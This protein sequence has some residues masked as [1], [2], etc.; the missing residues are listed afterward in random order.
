M[1]S[2]VNIK[3]SR[4]SKFSLLFSDTC[5]SCLSRELWASQICLLTLFAKINSRENFRIYSMSVCSLMKKCWLAPGRV[6]ASSEKN[7][8][9]QCYLTLLC[10]FEGKYETLEF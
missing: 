10:L 6:F 9:C 4:N 7:S 5:K 8:F 1:R 2:F 3:P